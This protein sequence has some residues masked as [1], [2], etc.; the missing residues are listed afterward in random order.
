M[1]EQSTNTELEFFRD[2]TLKICSSLNIEHVLHSC[3]ITLAQKIP[4]FG[5]SV[6]QY[7]PET[8]D[9]RI[10][11]IATLKETI[12]VDLK[13][14]MP[15]SLKEFASWPAEKNLKIINDVKQDPVGKR[16]VTAAYPYFKKNN[17][18]ML[19]LRLDLKDKR[20]I[21]DVCLYAEEDCKYTSE[22]AR[23]FGMLNEPFAIAFSNFL[24]HRNLRLTKER[25][26]A[27][28]QYLRREL[29]HLTGSDIIG[30]SP[31]MKKLNSLVQHV[32]PMDASVLLTGETGVGKEIVANTI[33]QHSD[34]KDGPFIKINCGAIP[35]SLIDSEL[36][37]HEKGAFTGATQQRRGRFELADS[38][39]IFLD[40]IGEMPFS[41]QVRL[42]RVLQDSAFERVGGSQSIQVN[43][44]VI[45]ATNQ[46]LPELINTGKFRQDLYFRLNVF[47]IHI[48]PLRIRKM[49]IP[50]LADH[51]IHKA[52]DK[53]KMIPPVLESGAVKKMQNYDWPGNVR[54]LEN[55]IERSLIL[56]TSGPLSI[57]FP[58]AT[59]EILQDNVD[60]DIADEICSLDDT[61]FRHIVMALKASKGKIQGRCGAAEILKI[62]PNTLR[63]KMQKLNIPYGRKI[64]KSYY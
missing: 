15:S 12:E 31:G 41:A 43:I 2:V 59:S 30:T 29:I 42:L 1:I 27:D 61:I 64:G 23:L 24:T 25:L 56:H 55:L 53:M 57:Q 46:D 63:K 37:G 11:A 50:L 62:N 3:L 14:N 47:P 32:A 49:D 8:N 33:Q 48:P 28:N 7:Q 39:T 44:R 52:S 6:H 17:L 60:K 38:G 10:M 5:M 22:H 18:P 13:F 16:L 26:D 9:F 20:R 40:E 51:F 19:A 21:A 35:E 4:V 45:A 54:E 34:R 58:N 36:F